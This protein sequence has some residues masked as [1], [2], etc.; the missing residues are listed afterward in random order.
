MVSCFLK[1]NEYNNNH[2]FLYF[3]LSYKLHFQSLISFHVSSSKLRCI[4]L[5]PTTFIPY[6]MLHVHFYQLYCHTPQNII[7]GCLLGNY[8]LFGHGHKW[9]SLPLPLITKYLQFCSFRNQPV[10]G[11]SFEFQKQQTARY[12]IKGSGN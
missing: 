10:Y 5:H 1:P 3:K 6:S 2:A 8:S 7:F 12:D 11:L 4:Q 9:L